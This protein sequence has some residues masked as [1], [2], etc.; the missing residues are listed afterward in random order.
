MKDE[1]YCTVLYVGSIDVFRI[2]VVFN[3]GQNFVGEKESFCYFESVTKRVS[4]CYPYFYVTLVLCFN[5]IM[6]YA[7]HFTYKAAVGM[8]KQH[9]NW[10]FWLKIFDSNVMS[11]KIRSNSTSHRVKLAVSKSM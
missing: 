6:T 8:L 5:R 4:F 9:L 3:G 1:K 10:L 7:I 2:Y 11:G